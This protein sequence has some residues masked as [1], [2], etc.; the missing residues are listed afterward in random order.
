MQLIKSLSNNFAALNVDNQ[1]YKLNTV[2][3]TWK[4]CSYSNCYKQYDYTRYTRLHIDMQLPVSIDNKLH[5]IA[6]SASVLILW[7]FT[8]HFLLSI[9]S[10]YYPA[11]FT[12]F[13]LI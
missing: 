11:S 1:L 6:T 10:C 7:F 2:M 12:A 3:H 8:S 13:F 9:A 4:S 5:L